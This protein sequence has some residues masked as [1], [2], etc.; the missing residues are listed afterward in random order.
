MINTKSLKDSINFKNTLKRGIY[1]KNKLL[2]IYLLRIKDEKNNYLGICVSKK[3]GNS[4]TR[5]RLKRWIKEIYKQQED[6]LKK[7]Y[8]IIFLFKKETE[9]KNV[10]FSDIKKQVEE[11]LKEVKV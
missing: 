7:G 11:L 10:L 9:G 6:S 2:S 1:T 8:N 3:N 5:N 4:V